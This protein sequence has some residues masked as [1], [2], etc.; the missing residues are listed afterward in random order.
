MLVHV[1]KALGA[2]PAYFVGGELPGAGPGGEP[3]NAG[4]GSGEWVVAEADESDGSFLD[5]RPEV[6]LVTN[7]EL[8]H[9][10]RWGS[11]AEL[12][13]AFRRFAAPASGLALLASAELDPIAAPGRTGGDRRVIRSSS[14]ASTPTR[15]PGR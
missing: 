6:A 3:A 9:H 4:W 15:R 2:D 1:L 8:D 14:P 5:L 13:D 12:V 11:R 7:V 10:S